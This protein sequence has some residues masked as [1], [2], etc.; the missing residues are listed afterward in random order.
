MASAVTLPIRRS[1]VMVAGLPISS[2]SSTRSMDRQPPSKTLLLGKLAPIFLVIS[3]VVWNSL[4]RSA[5]GLTPSHMK[6]AV[7][8]DALATS[9]KFLTCYFCC[10]CFAYLLLLLN[11]AA[12]II[13]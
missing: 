3:L 1:L 10:K 5:F 7:V 8:K 12:I 2:I 6:I 13:T 9:S 11:E 4:P